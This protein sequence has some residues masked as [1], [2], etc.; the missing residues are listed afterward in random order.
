MRRLYLLVAATALFIFTSTAAHAI[1]RVEGRYWFPT[2]DAEVKSGLLGTE[3]NLVDDLGEGRVT[4]ELGGSKLR[5]AFTPLSWDGD[6]T[7]TQSISFGGQTYS[8]SSQITS[9]L[10]V[11]YHRLGYE[12]DFIDFLNNKLGVIFDIKYF[13]V[14]ASLKTVGIDESEAFK[15]PIP[16]IGVVAQVGLPFL[17]SVGGEVTGITLGDTGHLVDGEAAVNFK[18]VPLVTLSGGYR[19]F[20][21]KY[22][23]DDNHVIIDLNGPF[24]QL[25]ASF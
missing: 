1:L 3:L 15:A 6:E 16:T 9:S 22:E 24:I 23:D 2:L 14:V 11:D 13:D 19:V 21:V 8:A 5:Y 4:L 18:P 12:Y 7:I 10:D 20:K 17:F 25:R